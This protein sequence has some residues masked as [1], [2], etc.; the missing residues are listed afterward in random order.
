MPAFP[1]WESVIEKEN[2]REPVRLPPLLF[3]KD[4]SHSG[5]PSHLSPL[6]WYVNACK[7]QKTFKTYHR[8]R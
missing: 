8:G 7:Q 5:N 1:H 2:G 6:M 3:R 4:S